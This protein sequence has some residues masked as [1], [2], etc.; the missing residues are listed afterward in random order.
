MVK[1]TKSRD[2]KKQ[3]GER[4]TKERRPRHMEKC[5]KKKKE[6]GRVKDRHTQG[7]KQIEGSRKRIKTKTDFERDAK[8]VWETEIS[9]DRNRPTQSG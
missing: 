2:W 1:V 4:E 9:K 3:E 5:T 6:T 8:R 7:M